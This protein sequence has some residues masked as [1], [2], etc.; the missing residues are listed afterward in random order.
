MATLKRNIINI[1]LT[2]V[3]FVFSSWFYEHYPII[4]PLMVSHLP[5]P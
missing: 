2:L 4:F 1:A 3:S 5:L